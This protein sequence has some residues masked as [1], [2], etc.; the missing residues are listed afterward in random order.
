MT[1]GPDGTPV[2]TAVEV[3]L[4]TDSLA[5]ISSGLTEGTAVVTGTASDLAGT[6]NNDGGF[7][8]PGGD[9]VTVPGGPVFRQGGPAQ[10]RP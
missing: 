5:E 10:G 4:V 8:P 7:G 1:L 2:P 3:G 6:T 9:V